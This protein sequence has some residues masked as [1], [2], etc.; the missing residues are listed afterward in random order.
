MISVVI[1]NY[2]T[3][4]IT[5]NCITSVLQHTKTSKYEIILVDNASTES[6]P[7]DFLI[8]FPNIKLI[9]NSENSGFAKGNNL[10][11]K[12][13][14][15]DVILL[16]NS[17]TYLIENTI[18][19]TLT[20]FKSLV[21]IGFLG[22]KMTYPDG[23]IQYTARK[24][25]TL[26]WELLDLFRFTLYLLP[27]NYR[28]SLMQGRYFKGDRD[29]ECDWLNGAFLMLN[30]SVLNELPGS[31]LDERFFMYGE[32]HLWGYQFKK[33]GYT[34]Y[35]YAGTSIVHINN[36]STSKEKRFSLLQIIYYNELEIIKERY[37]VG[38][39][40]YTLVLIYGFKEKTR[41]FI[42]KYL[43]KF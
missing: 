10:G 9:K 43:Y 6:N 19:K 4:D 8:R 25:R 42:K 38:I 5:C 3:F 40:F 23:R 30:R 11:I 41:M 21:N 22:V 31:K 33:L 20:N 37:G 39:Y 32:D 16:L 15:G 18:D 36:A 1:I 2:N 17:D 35:F 27:Y 7:D 28:S 12:H 14:T 29:L 24:F 13:S 34:N 26:K